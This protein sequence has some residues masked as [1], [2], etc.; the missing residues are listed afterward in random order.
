MRPETS[1]PRAGANSIPELA[2][3]KIQADQNEP[4]AG[5]DGSSQDHRVAEAEFLDR[6][7][8]NDRQKADTQNDRAAD[9]QRNHYKLQIRADSRDAS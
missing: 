6:D 2:A 1:L 9:Q 3:D 4:G 7:T 5:H 8:E